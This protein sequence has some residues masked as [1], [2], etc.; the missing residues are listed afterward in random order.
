MSIYFKFGSWNRANYETIPL[1]S[2]PFIS[3]AD[4]KNAIITKK[5]LSQKSSE[6]LVTNAQT[7]EEY[8]EDS[9]LV[10]KNTSLIVRIVPPTIS[11]ANKQSQGSAVGFTNSSYNNAAD[12]DFGPALAWEAPKPKPLPASMLPVV[13]PAPPPP[14][15]SI[16][17]AGAGSSVTPKTEEERIAQLINSASDIPAP[18]TTSYVPRRNTNQQNAPQAPYVPTATS[19]RKPPEG[20][21]CYR[22]Y[23]PG[24]FI[25]DCPTKGDPSFN[26]PKRPTTMYGVPTAFL[27]ETQDGRK[28]MKPN[29]REF[30]KLV[31]S[32]S[33][34]TKEIPQALSCP[35]CK[36]LLRNASLVP[37]C[38]ETTCDDCIRAELIDHTNFHCPLCQKEISP[39]QLMPNVAMRRAVDSFTA[40]KQSGAPASVSDGQ[41]RDTTK[42]PS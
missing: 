10:P 39:D 19:G 33:A 14:L 24:H 34:T 29:E 4:L 13:V 6:L 11:Y 7:D 20:Y 41:P 38:G 35:I 1:D 18:N 36:Q 25:S 30:H 31:T 3:V 5:K 28:E 42:D 17:L 32:D 22:C 40:N 16:P 9:T 15:P 21:V 8:R 23:Y 26:R 2:S 27:V 12:D 37:C